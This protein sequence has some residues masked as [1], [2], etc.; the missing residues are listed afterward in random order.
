MSPPYQALWCPH[1]ENFLVLDIFF[2]ALNYE[3]IEQKKAYDLAGLLGDFLN[4]PMGWGGAELWVPDLGGLT[5]KGPH[6]AGASCRLADGWA[7]CQL[8]SDPCVSSLCSAAPAPMTMLCLSV[9]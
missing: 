9:Q 6:R 7:C 8:S 5:R 3:A 4:L 2:E 1:R